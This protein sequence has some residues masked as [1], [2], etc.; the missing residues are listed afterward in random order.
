MMSC[1]V[2]LPD[3]FYRKPLHESSYVENNNNN[4]S[5]YFYEDAGISTVWQPR[6]GKMAFRWTTHD[7]ALQ[8]GIITLKGQKHRPSFYLSSGID[9]TIVLNRQV[10]FKKVVNFRDV[11]GLAT[12]DGRTVKWGRLYRSDNLSGLKKEEF[13]KFNDLH[14]QT[15]F[16]LRTANEIKGKEDNLPPNTSYVHFPTV[17]DNEDMLTKMRG[18][19]VNG[20]ITE[21]QSLQLMLQLYRGSIADNVPLLKE[22]VRQILHSDNP[23]LYHCSAG[24]DRTGIVTALVLLVLNVDRQT[25]V[26]EYL[27]SNY[28]RRAKLQ[29]I[30]TKATLAKAIKWHLQLKAIQ[31]FMAVDERYINAA[32]GLID[33]NYGGTDLFIQNQLGISADDRSRIIAKFTY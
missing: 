3:S 25:I 21:E 33:T 24:K 5:L 15:V 1:G 9:T 32:F 2:T 12:K 13:D 4:Y 19:V 30:L 27:L 26:N 28:Y 8:E 14:I 10:W 7:K 6:G 16:D 17:E 18:K 29:K 11:G 20:K 31:N 22:L 23:V